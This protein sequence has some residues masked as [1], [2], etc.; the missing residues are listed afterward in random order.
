M[1]QGPMKFRGLGFFFESLD[2]RLMAPVEVF[3]PSGIVLGLLEAGRL[4]V[5]EEVFLV[6]PQL[7]EVLEQVVGEFQQ[8]Q[9]VADF[10]VHLETEARKNQHRQDAE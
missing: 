3:D 9:A 10:P 1:F 8:P 6:P 7:Q 5:K 4:P 2:L